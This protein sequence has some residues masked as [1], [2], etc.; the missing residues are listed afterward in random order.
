[1]C[2][3]ISNRQGFCINGN[4]PCAGLAGCDTSTDYPLGQMCAVGTC[5]GASVCVGIN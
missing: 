1:M 3:S 2:M 4:M 5:Y